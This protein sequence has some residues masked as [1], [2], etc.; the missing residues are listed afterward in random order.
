MGVSKDH[1]VLVVAPHVAHAIRPGGPKGGH[2]PE[3]KACGRHDRRV[4][5]LRHPLEEPAKQL[6]VVLMEES[7][8]HGGVVARHHGFWVGFQVDHR[9]RAL[10]LIE[11]GVEAVA[12]LP[13]PR[14]RS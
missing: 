10:P 1:K 12:Q 5:P 11:R 6:L 4:F 2:F 14:P 3:T 8:V 7:H 13:L 9:C